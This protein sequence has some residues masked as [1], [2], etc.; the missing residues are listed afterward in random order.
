MVGFD[1][2]HLQGFDLE[3]RFLWADLLLKFTLGAV[4]HVYDW[5]GYYFRLCSTVGQHI[6]NMTT[7]E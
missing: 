6:W 2:R 7:A 1:F 3:E 5:N 4:G